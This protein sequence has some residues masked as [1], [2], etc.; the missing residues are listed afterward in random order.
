MG[1]K[2]ENN[3][4]R[5]LFPFS[6]SVNNS[7]QEKA[8]WCELVVEESPMCPTPTMRRGEMRLRQSLTVRRNFLILLHLQLRK[9]HLLR[10]HQRVRKKMAKMNDSDEAEEDEEEAPPPPKKRG[11]TSKNPLSEPEDA[12]E[13]PDEDDEEEV[14]PVKNTKKGNTGKVVYKDDSGGEDYTDDGE[15]D[16]DDSDF[17]EKKKSPR[18]PKAA[19]K[20]TPKKTPAKGK[21]AAKKKTPASASRASGRSSGATK[22]IKYS[23]SSE[24]D[25]SEEESDYDDEV[26]LKKRKVAKQSAKTEAKKI[27]IPPVSKMVTTAITRLRDNPRK[28]SSL[29]AIKGFMAEEWGL[30]IPDYAPKIKKYLLKAVETEEIKQTKGKGASGRFTLPGLK[31][32]KKKRAQKLGK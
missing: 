13:I 1:T 20:K 30:Y 8:E 23:Y 6:F 31:V 5:F 12:I 10:K 27:E 21:K 18:K 32:K 7:Q 16:G 15:V 4:N 22:P 29:S 11:R 3:K 2:K 9:E 14:V 25:M 26:P 28:G 17:E 19:K 24:S